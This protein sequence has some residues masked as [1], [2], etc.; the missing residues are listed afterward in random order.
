MSMLAFT[1]NLL[2]QPDGRIDRE[3]W[4]ESAHRRFVFGEPELIEGVIT[5]VLAISLLLLV[6]WLL[7][8]WQRRRQNPAPAQPL[9]LYRRVLGK[10]GLSLP[11]RWLLRRL[12]KASGI[13]H[14]TA[15]LISARLY[16]RAVQRYC[17]GSD[18]FFAR[19]GKAATFAMIRRRLFGEKREEAISS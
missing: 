15:L 2:A 9:S 1:S 4:Y 16:D 3:Q 7:Y 10:L 14:P 18:L 6:A 13:E 12:A 11:E 17:A 19:A 5:A 8:H